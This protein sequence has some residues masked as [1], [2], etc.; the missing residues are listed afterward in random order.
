MRGARLRL[1]PFVFGRN[2]SGAA[3]A[4]YA[5]AEGF[6]AETPAPYAAP[7]ACRSSLAEKVIRGYIVALALLF[8]TS[9]AVSQVD[10]STDSTVRLARC[11]QSPQASKASQSEAGD[12]P[13]EHPWFS[14]GECHMPG[15]AGSL[16]EVVG[17]KITKRTTS[18]LRSLTEN[19]LFR[20]VGVVFRGILPV[21]GE[22]PAPFHPDLSIALSEAVC[23]RDGV[24]PKSCRCSAAVAFSPRALA[25]ATPASV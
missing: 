12:L 3:V 20:P 24:P 9:R 8:P 13:H 7:A 2:A 23:R 1:R 5:L 6:H 14:A 17:F 25:D 16:R 10:A 11:S 15:P 18:K 21:A 4:G 19:D 22:E